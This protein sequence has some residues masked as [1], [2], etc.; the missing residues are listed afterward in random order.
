[1]KLKKTAKILMPTLAIAGLVVSLPLALTS[2]SSNAQFDPNTEVEWAVPRQTTY[3]Y[4]NANPQMPILNGNFYFKDSKY[5][6]SN[7]T[8]QW[9]KNALPITN[10]NSSQFVVNQGG[11]G[12]YYCQARMTVD[13]N[14]YVA[15]SPVYIVTGSPISLN[16][17]STPNPTGSFWT[18]FFGQVDGYNGT[19]NAILTSTD[20]SVNLQQLNEQG[21]IQYQWIQETILGQTVVSTNPNFVPTNPGLYRCKVQII[22]NGQYLI[23]SSS[24]KILLPN[25]IDSSL[26]SNINNVGSN[27]NYYLGTKSGTEAF[28]LTPTFKS[29][30]TATNVAQGLEHGNFD[31]D[32]AVKELLKALLGDANVNSILKN[33]LKEI[34]KLLPTVKSI[35]LE[36]LKEVL[37]T[38]SPEIIK[39]VSDAI[40]QLGTSAKLPETVIN[41]LQN[42]S[43]NVIKLAIPAIEKLLSGNIDKLTL[44]NPDTIIPN[45]NPLSK[46]ISKDLPKGT[47][48]G[49]PNNLQLATMWIKKIDTSSNNP[50]NPLTLS[51]VQGL[52]KLSAEAQANDSSAKNSFSSTTTNPTPATPTSSTSGDAPSKSSTPAPSI[53]SSD[54]IYNGEY[55]IIKPMRLGEQPLNVNTP[56]KYILVEALYPRGANTYTEY[57]Q[58]VNFKYTTVNVDMAKKI[59][60]PGINDSSSTQFT[61]AQSVI[62]AQNS[63]SA[64]NDPNSKDYQFLQTKIL[65]IFGLTGKANVEFILGKNPGNKNK[66]LNGKPNSEPL[67]AADCYK[68]TVKFTALP[69]YELEGTT[70]FTSITSVEGTTTLPKFM[71]TMQ[72]MKSEFATDL[73]NYAKTLKVKDPNAPRATQALVDDLNKGPA[74]SVMYKE[75]S[76]QINAALSKLDPKIP[77]DSYTYKIQLSPNPGIGKNFSAK[78]IF[79]AVQ[80]YG[81]TDAG[82]TTFS[83]DL[84]TLDQVH[85]YAAIIKQPNANLMKALNVGFAQINNGD[86]LSSPLIGYALELA[87]GYNGQA[88]YVGPATWDQT[89]SPYSVTYT[90][91]TVDK[92]KFVFSNG[93]GGTSETWSVTFK[94]KVTKLNANHNNPFIQLTPVTKTANGSDTVLSTSGQIVNV[95]K[96]L[97][98]IETFIQL[99]YQWQE[100]TSDD[101]SATWSDIPGANKATYSFKPSGSKYYRCKVTISPKL[102]TTITIGEP[103]YTSP[104]NV[105]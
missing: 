105:A 33:Y 31:F 89:K 54:T 63:L 45:G 91:K 77:A 61:Q 76:G 2:C 22:Y 65:N 4:S 96:Q 74:N 88:K 86:I 23:T 98:S 17:Q 92:N 81:F 44:P 32:W 41:W 85:G 68:V 15:T 8:Y 3:F 75:M 53:S 6:A 101:A 46:V 1:M 10:A 83:V 55:Q 29:Y 99:N 93:K 20:A 21:N 57:G 16:I 34:D 66:P 9:F 38:Y 12:N 27:G 37:A 25:A 36:K 80:G 90:F 39:L 13:G 84:G 70:S 102:L 60:I 40:N 82:L 24:Y 52:A 95:P 11:K 62:V 58:I 100:A 5:Q 30:N 51:A 104:L 14:Q 59:W 103:I 67:T 49:I 64:F 79:T 26:T 69:G 50:D 43:S 78:I 73:N 56:G 72:G 28:T 19:L 94:T 71:S 87:F 47:G 48:Y 42:N 97:S 7:V 35:I 18:K